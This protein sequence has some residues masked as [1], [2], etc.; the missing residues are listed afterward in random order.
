MYLGRIVEHAP[1]ADLF[2]A[3]EHPYT[4]A[5]LASVLTPEPG[6]GIPDSGLGDIPP[7]PAHIPSGC[8]LHPRCPVAEPRCTT[9][10]PEGLRPGVRLVECLLAAGLL[11]AR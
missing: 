3:P 5:L 6:L 1:V 11:P 2:S 10:S 9:E 7:D 4:K 8:R